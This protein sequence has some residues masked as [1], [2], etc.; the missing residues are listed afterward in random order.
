MV[1]GYPGP[2]VIKESEVVLGLPTDGSDAT[3]GQPNKLYASLDASIPTQVRFDA[4]IKLDRDRIYC[5]V[6]LSPNNS[7]SVWTATLGESDITSGKHYF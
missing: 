1:N 5:F 6:L 7:H 2:T 3:G 4:P